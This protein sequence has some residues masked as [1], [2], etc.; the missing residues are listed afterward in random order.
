MTTTTYSLSVV[1]Q[2]PA[3]DDVPAEFDV[4][5]SEGATNKARCFSFKSLTCQVSFGLSAGSGYQIKVTDYDDGTEYTDT[6]YTGWYDQD[7]I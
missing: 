7:D 3:T 2:T 4:V 1:W 5:V 6:Y